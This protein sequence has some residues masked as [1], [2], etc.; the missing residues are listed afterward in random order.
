[1]FQKFALA[2]KA[3]TFE[4]FADE[5][6]A[7]GGNSSDGFALLDYT[8]EVITGQRVVVIKRD[9]CRAA[10][11]AAQS[12]LPEPNFSTAETLGREPE[13]DCGLSPEST[14]LA[15]EPRREESSVSGKMN[16]GERKIGSE[17]SS[18]GRNDTTWHHPSIAEWSG[19]S[20]SLFVAP[21]VLSMIAL[22]PGDVRC[23]IDGCGPKVV[24]ERERALTEI[25]SLKGWKSDKI[26]DGDEGQLVKLVV[27]KVLIELKKALEL[28]IA[29]NPI[30]I[31][32]PV[33]E[34]MEFV[35]DSRA[36]TL[37]VV[38]H[39]EGGVGSRIII[40]TRDKSALDW[41][42]VDYEHKHKEMDEDEAKI[43][44]ARHAFRRNLPY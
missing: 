43:L 19:H 5:E 24:E 11:V 18:L 16:S 40:T 20:F 2:F 13:R 30:G 26:A 8:E 15:K 27:R 37:Y 39:G 36:S 31:Q 42:K 41:A 6:K 25:S 7:A 29:E 22:K 1:M 35:D 4:S 3:K 38:I 10:L 33:K 44:F 34:I 14:G 21:V 12:R 23:E 28:F 9:H 17:A 32:S